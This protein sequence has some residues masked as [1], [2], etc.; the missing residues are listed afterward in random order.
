MMQL[1]PLAQEGKWDHVL[2]E[3][4][5]VLVLSLVFSLQSSTRGHVRERT[6]GALK[7]WYNPAWSFLSFLRSTVTNQKKKNKPNPHLLFLSFLH[8]SLLS[9][10]FGCWFSADMNQMVTVVFL[11]FC[12]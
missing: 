2:E 1:Q 11:L 8:L 3:T 12:K 6:P 7:L 9:H 4:A 5:F 10:S